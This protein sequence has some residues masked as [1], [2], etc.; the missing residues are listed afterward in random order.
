MFLPS[1]HSFN[2]YNITKVTSDDQPKLL[3]RIGASKLH[4]ALN[5]AAVLKQFE[6]RFSQSIVVRSS[7]V[8]APLSVVML[9]YITLQVV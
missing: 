8:Y 1:N 3:D 2:Q 6:V 7:W 5:T 4:D 9:Q